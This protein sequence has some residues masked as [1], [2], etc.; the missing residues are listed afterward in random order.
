MAGATD[1][2]SFERTRQTLLLPGSEGA[3]SGEPY[4]TCLA[5]M[6][7]HSSDSVE[8]VSISRS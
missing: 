8:V 7:A 5:M 1:N 3:R 4:D 6:W 2:C